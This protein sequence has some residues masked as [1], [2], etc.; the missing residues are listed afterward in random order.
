MAFAHEDQD[1]IEK[2]RT[3]ALEDS[4]GFEAFQD[5]ETFRSA[6][7]PG[8]EVH[9][10]TEEDIA[11]IAAWRSSKGVPWTTWSY[12]NELTLASH[13]AHSIRATAAAFVIPDAT[14]VIFHNFV[15]EKE[16]VEPNEKNLK[17]LMEGGDLSEI[18]PDLDSVYAGYSLTRWFRENVSANINEMYTA[19]LVSY[20]WYSS[21]AYE[22]GSLPVELEA[23][24]ILVQEGKVADWIE[25]S[26]D[27]IK[28]WSKTASKI[29]IEGAGATDSGPYYVGIGDN[30]FFQIPSASALVDYYQ[31]VNGIITA[32]Q[33]E[34]APQAELSIRLA[35]LSKEQPENVPE[36]MSLYISSVIEY[37]D[38]LAANA[39][40]PDDKKIDRGGFEPST[41][42]GVRLDLEARLDVIPLDLEYYIK[43]WSDL[44]E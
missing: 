35:E 42:L 32:L 17:L 28:K 27:F 26:P 36:W 11:A 30:L 4:L 37:L 43:Y 12:E 15:L 14:L 41:L 31:K 20:A 25:E 3:I 34:D 9:E 2:Y 24:L 6:E 21:P 44:I 19:I 5:M 18:S 16:G 33:H 39:D 13:E 10:L 29:I 23:G 38:I 7:P 1:Y 22:P 8:H 40:Q